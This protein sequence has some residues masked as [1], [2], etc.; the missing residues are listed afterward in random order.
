MGFGNVGRAFLSLVNEKEVLCKERYGLDI[1]F[2]AIFRRDGAWVNSALLSTGDILERISSENYSPKVFYWITGFRLLEALE[3]CEPG[4]LVECTPSH[5]R[6][7]EP[8]LT[9]IHKALERGWHVVT[10]NK[11]PLVM[12]FA[13]LKDKAKRNAVALKISGAAAAALPTLD[14]ALYSLAGAEILRIEGILNGTTNFILTRM[15][16]GVG[17]DEAL[18]EAQAKGIAE[19][20][21]SLDVEG[22]D[23]ASKLLLIANLCLQ[24]NYSLDDVKVE[25]ITTISPQ[26]LQQGREEG[27]A[28]KLLGTMEKQGE[29]ETRLVVAPGIIDD[30][31]PLFSVEGTNKGIIFNTDSM[32]SVTVIGGKSDPRGAAAALIK[33]IIHIYHYHFH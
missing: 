28:L 25:G 11:G 6:D 33:D 18:K 29:D 20:D 27:K 30:S 23:T 10:A 31:H 3:S 2:V 22:W 21:P 17:Y 1:R 15:K 8:G 14:V 4:V 12:D 26:L 7:G 24:K 13:R 16:E 19:T 5:I 32:G 9:H